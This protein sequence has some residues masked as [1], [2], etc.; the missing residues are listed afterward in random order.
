MLWGDIKVVG[1][2]EA[3]AHGAVTI[4]NAIA[5]GK[6]A[7]FGINLMTTAK[8]Q[9]TDDA[10]EIQGVIAS[11]PAEEPTLIEQA[12]RLVFEHYNVKKYGAAVETESNIPIARGLKSSS[13]AANAL[14]L[15]TSAALGQEIDDFSA[16]KLSVDAAVKAGITITGAYD[17]ACASYFGNIVLTDNVN[18][19]ILKRDQLKEECQVIIHIPDKKSYTADLDVQKVKQIAP[20]VEKAFQEA[21]KGNYW[22]ALTIN[23]ALYSKVLGY[24]RK[25]ASEALNAGAIAAGLSGKGPAT[26]AVAVGDAGKRVEEVL[27]AYPGKIV[28]SKP[29]REKAHV[30]RKE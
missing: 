4:V 7:A 19:E 2:G 30:T 29:N 25:L 26:V 24:D 11:D 10:M 8:V 21:L 18:R 27:R 5:L 6:G 15:A 13:V 12:V 9:L 16:L 1:F 28:N 17:D 14:V 22:K 23:G 3:V 20:D